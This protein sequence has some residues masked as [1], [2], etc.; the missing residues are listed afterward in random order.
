VLN[1]NILFAFL[2][3][4]N[5]GFSFLSVPPALNVLMPLYGVSYT[6][7]SVLMSALMWTH[8]LMQIPA[9]L[10]ADRL[11]V[12]R[13]LLVS[14]LFLV[15]GNF[16]PAAGPFLG[17]AILG[18][19]VTGVGTGLGFV[20]LMKMIALHAPGERGGAFQ[21]FFGGLFAFGNILAYFLIP[22]LVFLHW[23]WVY[24][25]PGLFSLLVLLMS[26][27]LRLESRPSS[28]HKPASLGHIAGL[29]AAWI[30]G[31]F[32]A[33]SWGTMINLGNW[34]PS[35]LAEF[36]TNTSPARLA[37]GGML[38]MFV[39]GVG[40]MSGGFVLMRIPPL[41]VAN[42]SIL[43]LGLTLSGLFAASAPGLLLPLSLL[44]AFFSCVNFG[45]LFYLGSTVIEAESMATLFGFINFLANVG[46]VLFTLL[47]GFSKDAT[48]TFAWGFGVLAVLALGSFAV[49]QGIL[50]KDCSRDSCSIK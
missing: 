28:P 36:W 44:A 41:W 9:G 23:Q 45:A 3:A 27:G 34:I 43:F 8:A 21:A 26:F 50:R 17:L 13:S 1:G 30:L 15:C 18:R 16:L 14:L 6:G 12:R 46:A 29:R 39:S 47:F 40:R 24:L 2:S 19:I 35:L 37:W 48:G 4:L 49:G 10:L 38:V 11:G 22:R 20:T 31:L 7:I 5:V 33:M 25:A 42:A 32:H